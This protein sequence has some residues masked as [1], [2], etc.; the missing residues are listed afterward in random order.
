MGIL[1]RKGTTGITFLNFVEN[2]SPG[3]PDWRNTLYPRNQ[4]KEKHIYGLFFSELDL[5][6]E[7]SLSGY[8]DRL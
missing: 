6:E 7:N 4:S 2:Q 3:F 1:Y 5:S 8:V